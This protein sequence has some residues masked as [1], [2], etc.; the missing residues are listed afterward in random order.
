MN[1]FR[2]SGVSKNSRGSRFCPRRFMCRV[3]RN[4]VADV[5]TADCPRIPVC[6]NSASCPKPTKSRD[7]SRIAAP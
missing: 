1:S 7:R 6:R 4:G 5:Q 2:P 3:T